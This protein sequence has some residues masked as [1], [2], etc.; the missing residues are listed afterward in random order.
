MKI[1]KNFKKISLLI[2]IFI[3]IFCISVDA[4]EKKTSK[5]SP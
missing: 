4:A 3:A 5:K 1:N 2:T